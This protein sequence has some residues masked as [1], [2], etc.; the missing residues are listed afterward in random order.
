MLTAFWRDSFTNL[1]L[2]EEA[3]GK[4]IQENGIDF[5]HNHRFV[6]FYYIQSNSEYY[7]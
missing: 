2:K 3:Q 1:Q 7:L 4:E 6:I 5:K